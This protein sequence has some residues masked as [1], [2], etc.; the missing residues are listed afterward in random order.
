MNRDKLLE[1]IRKAAERIGKLTAGMNFDDYARNELLRSAVERQFEIAA[2]AMNRLLKLAPQLATTVTEYRRSSTF[3]IC[4][5]TVMIWSTTRLCG[6]SWR[7]TYRL[8]VVRLRR[9]LRNLA[10]LESR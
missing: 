4:S 5:A 6:A 8:F 1:D 7:R 10:T 3:A 9:F 2:E